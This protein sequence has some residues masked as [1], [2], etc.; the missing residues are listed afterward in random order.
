MDKDEERRLWLIAPEITRTTI[1]L[2]RTVVG[3]EPAERVPEE[4]LRVADEVLAEH[5]TDGLRV[6][7]MSITGWTAVGIETNAHLTGKSNEAYL[8]EMELTCLE[9]NADS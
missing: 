8:D 5:G 3:L 9:A 4:A 7:L 6:L 1:R 2:L